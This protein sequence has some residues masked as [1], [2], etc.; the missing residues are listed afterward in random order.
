MLGH[1]LIAT[2]PDDV[3]L[4]AVGRSDLD[5]TNELATS[6]RIAVERPAIIINAA[7]Y[8]AVD[9][10]ESDRDE[11]FRVNATAVGVVG[12]IAATQG[13]RVIHFS[14]DYVFDGTAVEPYPEDAE[15]NP[16]NVYGASKLAGEQALKH[17]GCDYLVI[18]TQWL[19]GQH[20]KC[21]PRSMLDR[22]RQGLRTRV[23]KDQRG[24]PTF[25]RD[26][27]EATWYLVEAATQGVVHVA[28]EGV[29]TWYDL[30]G[31]I[32]E[33]VGVPMLVEA[34]LSD[35]YP[36]IAK[37]PGNA[38]LDTRLLRQHIGKA[39]PVWTT[40]VDRF[41]ESMGATDRR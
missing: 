13:A 1:D 30:A 12:R 39:L 6:Q 37:R 3:E 34:C 21:F 7:A 22:A 23:V 26:V 33:A 14:T 19:F 31:R 40:G 25:A 16:I 24:R 2:A 11:A 9:K 17:S 10:A 4:I 27:A 8:T 41:L 5:I 15:T 35:E 18:R 29:T 38:V 28:N 20:G 36:S 32:F